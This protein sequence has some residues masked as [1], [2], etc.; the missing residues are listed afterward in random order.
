MLSFVSESTFDILQCGT[1]KGYVAI[2]NAKIVN[3]V[4]IIKITLS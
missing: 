1:T 2:K 4:P 3:R